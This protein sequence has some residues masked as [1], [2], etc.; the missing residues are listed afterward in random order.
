MRPILSGGLPF[1]LGLNYRKFIAYLFF[2][3]GG[4]IYFSERDWSLNFLYRY[5][6][7]KITAVTTKPVKTSLNNKMAN[8]SE[9][10]IDAIKNSRLQKAI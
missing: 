2:V 9:G 10:K 3:K 1:R 4:L 7:K 6:T 5:E 8:L